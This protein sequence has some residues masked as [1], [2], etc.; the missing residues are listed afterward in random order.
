MTNGEQKVL[1]RGVAAG[2]IVG[3]ALGLMIAL[4]VAMKPQLF[5]GLIR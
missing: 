3:L 5:A 2:T 1:W 4:F